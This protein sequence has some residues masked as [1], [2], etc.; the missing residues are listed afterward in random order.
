[1][2][3]AVLVQSPPPPPPPTVGIKE[4]QD[5]CVQVHTN[6]ISYKSAG[7]RSLVSILAASNQFNL[8]R[9][10]GCVLKRTVVCAMQT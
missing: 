1:M 7:G 9:F 4:G 2:V 8:Q 3:T 6:V 10:G 5:I